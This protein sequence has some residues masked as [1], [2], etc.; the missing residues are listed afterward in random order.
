[1]YNMFKNM[2]K[3]FE[4]IKFLGFI[5]G[6]N[7]PK[8][9]FIMNLNIPPNHLRPSIILEGSKRSENDLTFKLNEIVKANLRLKS[10]FF[11]GSPELVIMD[12]Y[13]LFEYHVATYFNNELNYYPSSQHRSGKILETLI[14][15]IKGK[16]GRFRS[17]LTGKRTDFSARTTIVP[18]T[19]YPIERILIPRMM[20]ENLTLKEK[21]TEENFEEIREKIKNNSINL[22]IILIISF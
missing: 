7:S 15:R 2:S 9:F 18:E 16:G 1:M 6:I 19:K 5:N 3:D 21:I 12:L 13:L 10:F 14:Q 4:E 11:E 17:N 22:I 8:D 20:A